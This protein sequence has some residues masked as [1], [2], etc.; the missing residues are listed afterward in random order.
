MKEKE[1]FYE[2][3]LKLQE[4][5]LLI[6]KIINYISN[7]ILKYK[8]NIEQCK[9]NNDYNNIGNLQNKIYTLLNQKQQLEETK[10]S[11]YFGRLNLYE[12]NQNED[13]YIGY[14]TLKDENENLII[15]GWQAPICEMFYTNKT[16]MTINKYKYSLKLKRKIYIENG[17]LI[18]VFD[19]I[20]NKSEDSFEISDTFLKE[21]VSRRKNEENIVDIVKTIQEKQNKI[22]RLEKDKNILCQG[23]AGSGKTVIIAHR[24]SYLLYN[25][26]EIKPEKY[27]FITPNT[28]FKNKLIELENTLLINN[29]KYRTIDEFYK[30][31]INEILQNDVFEKIKINLIVPDDELVIEKYSKVYINKQVTIINNYLTDIL[32]KI[33]ISNN[34]NYDNNVSIKDN[35]KNITLINQDNI[36]IFNTIIKNIGLTIDETILKINFFGKSHTNI[37]NIY[38]KYAKNTEKEIFQIL[39]ELF[40][41]LKDKYKS[42]YNCILDDLFNKIDDLI[43][44]CNEKDIIILNKVNDLLY[45]FILFINYLLENSNNVNVE[46]I[47]SLNKL[48]FKIYEKIKK[49]NFDEYYMFKNNQEQLLKINSAKSI[50]KL[51]IKLL[52]NDKYYLSKIEDTKFN[53]NDIFIILNVLNYFGF[54]CNDNYN[55]IFLDESQDYNDEEINL[56]KKI[57]KN[58]ILNIFGDINQNITKTSANRTN[59]DSLKKCLNLNFSYFELNENYRN[60]VEIVSYCNEN[61]NTVMKPMGISTQNIKFLSSIS[62]EKLK[63]LATKEKYVIISN[64]DNLN[65]EL[66]TLGIRVLNLFE[67]KGLEFPNVIIVDEKSFNNKEKYVAYTRCKN[68][69]IVVNQVSK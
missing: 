15:C 68:K 66:K 17:K 69:L 56:I 60:P 11:P 44:L 53:R 33:F 52:F 55:F 34:I 7:V 16:E 62:Y 23:V 19:V 49:L 5:K 1:I 54:S 38:I 14:K 51:C 48:I 9:D 65:K 36:N 10:L 32:Q 59:W 18:N 42:K 3:S 13:F 37:D 40:K 35:I 61:L 29:I 20:N 47:E 57:E 50:V 12:K 45:N 39:V 63:K 58:S 43:V 21:V 28:E 41:S 26:K 6:K 8:A 25:Y 4:N 30:E 24:I 22:I 27:L 64:N 46:E 31:K 67:A 2:E